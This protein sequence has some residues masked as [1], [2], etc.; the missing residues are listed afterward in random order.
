M[1]IVTEYVDKYSLDAYIVRMDRTAAATVTTIEYSTIEC[2]AC[3]TVGRHV[4]V[5]FAVKFNDGD[6][7]EVIKCTAT[8]QQTV[9]AS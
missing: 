6:Y 7:G 4:H 9:W 1:S 8:G 3:L 5:V 2:P